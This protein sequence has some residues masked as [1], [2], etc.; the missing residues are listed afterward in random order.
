MKKQ[1]I[2][3]GALAAILLCGCESSSEIA[4]KQA[5]AAR[6]AADEDAQ[7]RSEENQRIEA[8]RE[9]GRAA[10]LTRNPQL[11][12]ADKLAVTEQRPIVGLSLQEAW[13][14]VGPMFKVTESGGVGGVWSVW[15]KP[16]GLVQYEL[17]FLNGRLVRWI[18]L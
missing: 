16:R 13:D 9:K 12:E 7:K 6:S 2:V 18:E 5:R 15:K 4:A 11:T 1:L 3:T 17:Y 8:E 10:F 14:V